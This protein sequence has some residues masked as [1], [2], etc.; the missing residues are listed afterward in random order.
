VS[1]KLKRREFISLIGGAA[2][3]WPLAARAQQPATPVIGFLDAAS[4]PE[5][6][7]VLAAFRQGLAE[8]G[9]VEGRNLAIEFRWAEGRYDRLP[10]LAADLVHRNVSVIAAPGTSA[11][12]LAAKAATA[13]IPIVFGVPGDPVRLGLV[14][15]LSRPGGNATG[16]NFFTGEVVAKRMQLLRELVP[17][18]SRIAVL[19]NP[20]DPSNESTR[21]DVEPVAGVLGIFVLEAATIGEIDAAFAHLVREKADALFVAPGVFF[22]AR[23]VQL[24]VL[25]ARHNIP[26]SFS[27]RA[28]VE[29]GGLVSY[30]ADL[31]DAFRQ[32]GVY[33]ARILQ[34]AKPADLP[35]QQSIKFELV[36]NLS[37]ARALG[38]TI[39]P[40]LL[41]IADEVI[42]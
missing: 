4:A 15:S 20:S 17:A 11:A 14:K 42:E 40:S 22:S 23:R 7:W 16:V 18:A 30:G 32:A 41:A 38:L 31:A 39:P 6:G 19:V 13:I 12:G 35:V 24:A 34:G 10:E 21:S 29:A 9:F 26:A 2:A 36:I 3:T 8:G 27:S 33:T 25:A 28:A 5:R 1:A 37:T